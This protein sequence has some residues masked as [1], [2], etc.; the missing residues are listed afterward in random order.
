[1]NQSHGVPQLVADQ[2]GVSASRVHRWKAAGMPDDSV[3]SAVAWLKIHRPKQ[4]SEPTA[5]IL[6][7]ADAKMPGL[8]GGYARAHALEKR[9]WEL[10]FSEPSSG[11]VLAHTKA[12]ASVASACEA[13]TEWAQ[14]SGQL[15][16]AQTIKGAW[17]AFFSLM[18]GE[19][20]AM[21]I[22]LGER[23]GGG[24]QAVLTE[25]RDQFLARLER[26]QPFG[27]EEAED[28]AGE[29]TEDGK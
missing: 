4:F 12:M 21:P 17:I 9:V 29:D 13:A 19:L 26:C 18:R 28:I 20:N 5:D 2:F 8:L 25:W 16:D 22:R 15:V 14:K 3:D 6:A 10:A 27:S 24:S 1:M 23:L 7:D 11:N